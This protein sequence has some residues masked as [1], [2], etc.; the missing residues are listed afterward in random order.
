M[1]ARASVGGCLASRTRLE[2]QG[3]WCLKRQ[4]QLKISDQKNQYAYLRFRLLSLTKQEIAT[5]K[6]AFEGTP[7]SG[8]TYAPIGEKFRA[9]LVIIGIAVLL[10]ALTVIV[11]KFNKAKHFDQQVAKYGELE[12]FQAAT[13]QKRNESETN[14]NLKQ[15][16]RPL[17]FAIKHGMLYISTHEICLLGAFV[18]GL[19]GSGP[20]P[21]P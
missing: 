5:Q 16:S 9:V 15:A 10:W 18:F 21:L 1:A 8:V 4:R 13:E 7:T 12:K 14:A 2:S 19:V 17:E 3:D 20:R 6:T 11:G